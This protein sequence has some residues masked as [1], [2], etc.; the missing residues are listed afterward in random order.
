MF[1]GGF[2]KRLLLV[3]LVAIAVV[4]GCQSQTTTGATTPVPQ[5][6]IAA[7][8]LPTAVPIAEPT[9]M[10][11]AVPVATALPAPTHALPP[12]T[13]TRVAENADDS[14]FDSLMVP[15]V[16]EARKRR[17]ALAKGDPD[18]VRRVDAELNKS[19][20]N[21]LLFGYGETHEPPATEK[22]I[23]GSHT[24]ISY[25]TRMRKVDLVS[26][27]H[28]IRSPEV[29][30]ELRR[31][32][33]QVPV[34]RIDKAYDV[35]GFELQRRVLQNATGLSMD[36]QITFKDRVIQNVVDQVFQGVDIDNPQEFSVQPFYLD[37]K[38]YP[39]GTFPRGHQVLN[40]VRVIQYIKTVPITEGYYGKS[41]EHN[42]RKHLIFQALLNSLYKQSSNRGFW[43]RGSAL[44]TGEIIN[45]S[46]VYDFDPVALMVNNIGST[47]PELSNKIARRKT[48]GIDMPRIDKTIYIVDKQHGD[49]G[50]QWV[51]PD[52]R[53]PYIIRD[54][55]IGAYSAFYDT[56]VP[57]WANPYGDPVTEYWPSVRALV[58][59]SLLST[60]ESN[61]YRQLEKERR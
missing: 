52:T 10:P 56:A 20:I 49:G 17:A 60:G 26:L 57:F 19:R 7:A 4:T 44:V 8:E 33:S 36:F 53:D 48:S 29:E 25:D 32:T 40:G 13:E 9:P 28:D 3:L 37:G 6:T 34:Q 24:I 35:G 2:T 39:K 16:N 14:L 11:I 1:E 27:T 41:L 21:F 55:R 61:I 45:Q 22:A 5:P 51:S 31:R 18:Y 47:L 42:A 50:V 23:I 54:I 59:G 12:A 15:F 43:L 38:K 30:Q 58:K 46:V